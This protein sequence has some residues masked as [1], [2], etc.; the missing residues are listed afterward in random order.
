MKMIASYGT[1]V[2]L[3]LTAA[4]AYFIWHNELFAQIM[5]AAAIIELCVGIYVYN[6]RK[7]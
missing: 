7:D 4:A 1:S 2:L 6:K 3:L 5:C